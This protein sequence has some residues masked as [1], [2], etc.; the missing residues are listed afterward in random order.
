MNMN[1]NNMNVTVMKY[2][3]SALFKA[4]SFKNN[5]DFHHVNSVRQNQCRN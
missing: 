2:V 4:I 1:N 5:E 3:K